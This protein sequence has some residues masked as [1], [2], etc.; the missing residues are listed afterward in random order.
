MPRNAIDADIVPGG[1]SSGSAVA[2]AH[3]LVSFALGTDTAGSGRVP[4]ALNN[5]VGLKPTL[6][7]LSSAGVVPACKTLDTVSVFALN[8]DD[9]Y[10]VF[11][12]ASEFDCNDPFSRAVDVPEALLD[13]GVLRV[14]APTSGTLEFFGD[15]I[16]AGAFDATLALTAAL[17]ISVDRFDFTPCA[18]VARMLYDGA[19]VAERMTVVEELMTSNPDAIHPVTRKVIAAADGKRAVDVFNDMYARERLRHELERALQD[20][21]VLMVP[22][23]PTFFSV[24]QVE[25]EPV[26]TNTRLGTYTN[27]VNLLDMC[28]I[29]VP[30]GPRQ[31]DGLAVSR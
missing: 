23:I 1:S 30:T 27:F 18:E 14:A 11:A 16:Q 12:V 20:V 21:D 28:A 2:V 25:A 29:A 15:E 10:A 3:G 9:A 24:A 5:I 4:A 22:S 7:A 26:L 19:W 31:M 13:D 6:G 8:V 17:G